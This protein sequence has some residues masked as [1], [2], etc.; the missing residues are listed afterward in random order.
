MCYCEKLHQFFKTCIFLSSFAIIP[1]AKYSNSHTE[2][3]AKIWG[4]NGYE[5]ISSTFLHYFHPSIHPSVRQS[6]HF[7]PII[8][9][10]GNKLKRAAHT[11]LSP[12]AAS[13]SFVRVTN[14]FTSQLLRVSLPKPLPSTATSYTMRQTPMTSSAMVGLQKGRYMWHLQTWLQGWALAFLSSPY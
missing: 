9:A 6:V 7:L 2:V 11:S 14:V 1:F 13:S 10:A 5:L 12:I 4:C 3:H 8:W